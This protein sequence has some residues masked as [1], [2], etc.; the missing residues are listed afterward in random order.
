MSSKECEEQLNSLIEAWQLDEADLN[1]TDIYAIKH[2]LLKNQ[3]QQE[4]IK[5][6]KERIIGKNSS[7]K[8]LKMALKERTDERD[9]HYDKERLYKE[10]IEEVRKYVGSREMYNDSFEEETNKLLQI[11]DKAKEMVKDE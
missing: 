8:A 4:E 2:L 11:L 7:I 5:K 3:M 1:A 6:L 9:N 10:V